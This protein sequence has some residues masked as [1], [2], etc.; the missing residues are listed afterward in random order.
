MKLMEKDEFGHCGVVVKTILTDNAV[1]LMEK[2][3]I[4]HCGV[5]IKTILTDNVIMKL[6]EKKDVVLFWVC[7]Q[8]FC[9]T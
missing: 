4:G 6:M 5:V 7:L 9:S 2:D 3:K 1:K 8:P